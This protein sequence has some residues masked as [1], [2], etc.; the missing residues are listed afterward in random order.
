ML[1][2]VCT[3]ILLFR[4]TICG[5]QLNHKTFYNRFLLCWIDLQYLHYISKNM[6]LLLAYICFLV[7]YLFFIISD[8]N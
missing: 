1:Q 8:I 5:T 2:N 6:Y 4:D 7:F 3:V